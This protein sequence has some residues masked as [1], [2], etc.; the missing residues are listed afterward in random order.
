MAAP[1]GMRRPRC[2]VRRVFAG[3]QCGAMR[4]R[5]ASALTQTCAAAA[6]RQGHREPMRHVHVPLWLMRSSGP[7]FPRRV[8]HCVAHYQSRR[9]VLS[10]WSC[11][12]H[13]KLLE[14]CA[15][16]R[17]DNQATFGHPPPAVRAPRRRRAA[18]S[19]RRW[20][21]AAPAAPP[22]GCRRRRCRTPP[23]GSTSRRALA[24]TIMLQ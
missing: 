23:A 9:R 3:A 8:Q 7:N 2:A 14:C 17:C 20:G 11:E 21:T 6:P 13:A 15:P 16:K 24:L 10:A 4:V 1:L 12:T 19:P 5:G 22:A 18:P